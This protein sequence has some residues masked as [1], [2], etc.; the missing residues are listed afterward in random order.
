MRFEE[1]PF[2]LSYGKLTIFTIN[3]VLLFFLL[4][5]MSL[6]S[7][8]VS[9]AAE[10]GRMNASNESADVDPLTGEASGSCPWESYA[11]YGTP[12]FRNSSGTSSSEED[13]SSGDSDGSDSD[14]T[15]GTGGS[16]GD[17]NGEGG[18]SVSSGLASSS[19]SRRKNLET[20]DL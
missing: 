20:V 9:R 18:D 17:M 5:T 10:E 3:L 7:R 16:N 13:A 11:R 1:D 12:E 4:G 14:E 2:H 8:S 15:N 19:S 6:D